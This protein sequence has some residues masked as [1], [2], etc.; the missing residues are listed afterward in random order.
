MAMAIA[1]LRLRASGAFFGPF[2]LRP[3]WSVPALYSPITFDTF[4][5]LADLVF[6]IFML[7]SFHAFIT[8]ATPLL[9]GQCVWRVGITLPVTLDF[10]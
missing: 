7:V 5:C 1:C 10:G 9:T 4:A 8:F 3:A 6:G 2:G